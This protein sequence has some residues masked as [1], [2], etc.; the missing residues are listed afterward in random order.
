MYTYIR[1]IHAPSAFYNK[2]ACIRR[3]VNIKTSKLPRR[4]GKKLMSYS[5]HVL[6]GKICTNSFVE[7][8]RIFSNLPFSCSYGDNAFASLETN[9]K[10]RWANI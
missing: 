6:G 5:Y 1:F 7:Q 3:Q 9:I 2:R 4:C 10:G 8:V